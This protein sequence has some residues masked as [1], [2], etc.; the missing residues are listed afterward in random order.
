MTM[1]ES[2]GPLTTIY[3]SQVVHDLWRESELGKNS[4]LARQWR[5]QYPML[6][7]DDDLAQI[8]NQASGLRMKG[9]HFSE[10]YTAIYL[11]QREGSRSLVEKYDTY[12]NHAL[13]QKRK[14]D[15]RKAAEYE[16]VVRDDHRQI[17]HEICSKWKVGLPDLLV[18]HTD[19]GYSFAEVK[20]PWDHTVN[21][22]P[23]VKMRN[24]IW[25]RLR[26]PTEVVMVR[27]LP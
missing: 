17:H 18:I 24:E 9:F 1:T 7:S 8:V 21:R 14:R 12:E 26:V 19:G 10:W 6:F 25:E 2:G 4:E 22:E 3:C 16:R 23:E 13:N 20:G 27:L 11:F 5:Q 15:R